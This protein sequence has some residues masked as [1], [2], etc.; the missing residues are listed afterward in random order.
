VVKKGE[1]PLEMGNYLG[2]LTDE[3][4]GDSIQEFVAT[5]PKSYAYQ[6][7]VAMCVKGIPQTQ[8]CCELVN[9][10]RVRSGGGLPA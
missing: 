1:T 5:G 4:D 3:L 9:F 7:K 10:D 8:E 6:T 2:D